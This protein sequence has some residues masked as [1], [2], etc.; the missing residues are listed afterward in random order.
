MNTALVVKVLVGLQVISWVGIMASYVLV[1]RQKGKLK[2][3]QRSSREIVEYIQ[4][5]LSFLL[6]AE[7]E[8]KSQEKVAPT[9]REEVAVT[10]DDHVKVRQLLRKAEK[11]LDEGD[12]AEVE[13]ILIEALTYNP[14]D[15]DVNTTLAYIYSKQ[16]KFSKAESIYVDLIEQGAKDPAVFSG[17]GRVLEEQGRFEMA[18]KAYGEALKRDQHNAARHATIGALCM[19]HGETRKGIDAYEQALRYETKN[20]DHMFAL[21]DGYT[22]LDAL[23]MA[24]KY[25]DMILYN[26]PYNTKANDALLAI[27]EQGKIGM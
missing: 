15:E 12:Y 25:L 8:Q 9:L 6:K 13:K 4:G 11:F 10:P 27:K 24:T 5:K 1:R 18:L 23:M 7:P 14:Q 22:K 21:V 2:Q 16:E 26:E 19:R 17:L 3:L 20:I